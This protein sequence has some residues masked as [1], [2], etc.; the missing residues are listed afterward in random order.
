MI[1]PPKNGIVFFMAKPYL[2][3]EPVS[4]FFALGSEIKVRMG[5]KIVVD[6]TL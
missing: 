6:T 5:D 2:Q 3:S 1:I 4:A